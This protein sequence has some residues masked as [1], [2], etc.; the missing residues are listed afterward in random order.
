MTK[1]ND[2]HADRRPAEWPPAPGPLW[3][4]VVGSLIGAGLLALILFG[5]LWVARWLMVNWPGGLTC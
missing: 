4:R 3:A 5:M 1:I 2:A